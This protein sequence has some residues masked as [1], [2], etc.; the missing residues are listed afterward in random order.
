MR[1]RQG[2]SIGPLERASGDP[3]YM[4][5]RMLSFGGRFLLRSDVGGAGVATGKRLLAQKVIYIYVSK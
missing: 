1:P 2:V 5:R 3:V 4:L